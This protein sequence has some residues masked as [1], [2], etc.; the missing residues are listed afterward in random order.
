MV[1]S[2]LQDFTLGIATDQQTVWGFYI[3]Y[4]QSYIIILMNLY[5][6]MLFQLF[7]YCVHSCGLLHLFYVVYF[8]HSADSI[9]ESFQCSIFISLYTLGNL[10]YKILIGLGASH[11]HGLSLIIHYLFPFKQTIHLYQFENC[12]NA[13]LFQEI[14]QVK[15]EVMKVSVLPLTFYPF[16]IPNNPHQKQ[17]RPPTIRHY[18][19]R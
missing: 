12:N 16:K 10:A 6:L 2:F 15:D 11:K 1:F 14:I 17:M 18:P 19:S 5:F 8:I 4:T 3:N 7:T 13:H 9:L